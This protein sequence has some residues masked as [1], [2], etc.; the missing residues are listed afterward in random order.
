MGDAA[1]PRG[2]AL[3]KA[4]ISYKPKG[5]TW[6]KQLTQ[7]LPKYHRH[8]GSS[9]DCGP[10]S[11]MFVA[12]ALLERDIVDGDALARKME[13]P[14]SVSGSLIPG[15]IKGWATFPWGVARALRGYGLR[16]RWRV[17]A[18][19]RD[20]Y[21]SL[22]RKHPTIVIVGD[23]LR[24]VN[25]KYAGW[26]HYKVLYAWDPDEGFAFVDPAAEDDV[27]FSTQDAASFHSQWSAMGRQLIEVW[28]EEDPR[29]S[30]RRG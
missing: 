2:G 4:K 5:K 30:K 19:L 22:N 15:R 3:A 6:K 28:Q 11:V 17:G 10:Y 12:N 25:G 24:F 18:A 23:P 8:Q 26:S 16:V 1:S 14:P 29:P 21:A 7:P 9:N 20:L 27:A 13:G